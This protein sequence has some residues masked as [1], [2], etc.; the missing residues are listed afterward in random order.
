EDALP[1]EYRPWLE[2]LRLRS[3]AGAG[4][5]L[6]LARAG[7]LR[8]FTA[9]DLDQTGLPDAVYQTLLRDPE[10]GEQGHLHHVRR[11]SCQHGHLSAVFVGSLPLAPGRV[12]AL[13]SLV[14]HNNRAVGDRGAQLLAESPLL[15]QLTSLDLEHIMMG[16]EG[17]RALAA[18][19]GAANL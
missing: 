18:S 17:A 2:T 19:P 5:M 12:A 16:A 9:L 1:A 13:R 11:L 8:P 14:L 3:F 7:W 4:Q 6:S 15:G 10:G